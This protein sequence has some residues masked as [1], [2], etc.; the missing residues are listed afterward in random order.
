MS[1][2]AIN[3]VVDAWA[4]TLAVVIFS[5]VA[6]TVM[7]ASE[8]NTDWSI[9]AAYSTAVFAAAGKPEQMTVTVAPP[10]LFNP[11]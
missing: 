6:W 4:R 1:Q 7:R 5:Q 2:P 3:S 8:G 11:E 10:F 9:D